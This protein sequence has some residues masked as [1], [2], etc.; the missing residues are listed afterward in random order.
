MMRH[1]GFTLAELLT[2]LGVL[3]VIASF[4]IPK[5]LYAQELQQRKALLK[6]TVA[7]ISQIQYEGVVTGELTANTNTSYFSNR[8]NAL[9]ICTDAAAQGCW[10]SGYN[11]GDKNE[12]GARLANGVEM[13]GFNWGD[14]LGAGRYGNVITID[15]NGAKGPNQVGEDV[16]RLCYCYGS[17]NCGGASYLPADLRPGRN[18]GCFGTEVLYQSLFSGT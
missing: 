9:Q 11:S 8:L 16:L 1:K 5:M 7:L 4:S 2:A 10:T 13:V 17:L 3:G 15:Y 14:N 12:P 6:E 18:T